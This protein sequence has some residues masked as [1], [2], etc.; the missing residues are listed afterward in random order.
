MEIEVPGKA[1]AGPTTTTG[2]APGRDLGSG[3]R[4]HFFT[5]LLPQ[6]Y[7]GSENNQ[8]ENRD[9]R[10]EARYQSGHAGNKRRAM[11]NAGNP[12]AG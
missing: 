9:G 11:V 7:W 4:L 3:G 2:P 1:S 5:Y 8:G 10:V 6:F 12:D